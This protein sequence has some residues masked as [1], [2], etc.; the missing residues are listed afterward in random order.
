LLFAF[1]MFQEDNNWLNAT[2]VDVLRAGMQKI[3][4]GEEP[5][6]WPK[7]LPN[8]LR[9]ILA[10]RSGVRD[11]LAVFWPAYEAL[12]ADQKARLHQALDDQTNLPGIFGAACHCET[13]IGLPDPVVEAAGRLFEFAFEQLKTLKLDGKCIRDI[14]YKAIYDQLQEKICPFCGLTHFRAPGAPRHALDHYLP[15]SR[16]TFVGSDFRNLVPCC[17]ECNSDFKGVKDVLFSEDGTRRQC[18]D[19]YTGPVYRVSLQ[20]SRLFEGEVVDGHR[21]PL[22]V[23]DLVGGPAA[24]AQTW[25]EVYRIRERYGRDIL[26]VSFIPWVDDFARYYVQHFGKTEQVDKVYQSLPDYIAGLGLD[27]LRE[28]AFLKTEALLLI[29]NTCHDGENAE[30]ARVWLWEFVKYGV[31]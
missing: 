26:N 8:D 22:W 2:L 5:E 11:R 9:P 4:D 13:I 7:C 14:Q 3:D 1:P 29:H 21:V 16:Y 28:R 30:E 6:I 17:H 19:P 10:S 24:H 23:I 18:C 31:A 15:A 12:D 25:D 20:G 27:N